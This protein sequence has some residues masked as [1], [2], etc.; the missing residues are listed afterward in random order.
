MNDSSLKSVAPAVAVLLLLVL[1]STAAHAQD[2]GVMKQPPVEPHILVAEDYDAHTRV[3]LPVA[4]GKTSQTSASI[5]VDY[6]GFSA[7]AQQAFQYATDLWERHIESPVPIRVRATWTAL[8]EN[9]LGSAGPSTFFG[10]FTNAPQTNTWYPL[11]LAQAI[12]GQRFP[13]AP[14]YDIHAN[15]SSS[16]SWYFGTDGNTPAG[17]FDLV[18][19]VLHE[20]G[21]GL[22]FIQTYH[23]N[24]GE[25]SNRCPGEVVGQGCWGLSSTTGGA[26]L[27]AV[28]DRF[29]VDEND[30][31]LL[32]QSVYGNP[33]RKLG[34][35]LQSGRVRFDGPS[36][37]SAHE[38]VPIDLYAPS[39]FEPASSIAHL[40]ESTFPRGDI[41]SLM[42]PRLARAEAIHTPGPIFCGI[43]EDLGWTLGD[44]CWALITADII[45]FD[46]GQISSRGRVQLNWTTGPDAQLSEFVIQGSHFGREYEE[47]A[48]I[49]FVPGQR[50]YSIFVEDLAPGRYTFRIRYERVDGSNALS[51]TVDATVPL[52]DQVLVKG[53][54][55]NP[56][57]TSA[58]V[59]VQV[60][61]AQ[62]F[63]AFLYD[64]M[65]RKVL[66]LAEDLDVSGQSET[67]FMIERGS[68]SSGVYF[69]QIVGSEFNETTSVVI[70]R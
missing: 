43:L 50:D 70:A 23:V 66:T 11:G 16:M 1:G 42:T 18:T 32:D 31:S 67:T 17:M 38:N 57:L 52:Q 34:D 22:G 21:H 28:F 65:G 61:R 56:M 40:D 60:R 6:Q 69:L 13:E 64:A 15:F 29:V 24:D 39:G 54:F 47:V 41:N 20:I 19:V 44:G 55:P 7:E 62:K 5:L 8:D 26:P 59:R 4:A 33:S 30:V 37:L 10:N 2:A 51:R 35:V 12:A 14:E 45:A 36:A 68:L 9:V 3:V 53:P 27:P 25:D 58:T 63:S 49:D 48:R 46:T